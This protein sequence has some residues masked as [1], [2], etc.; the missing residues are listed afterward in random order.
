MFTK[1]PAT[2]TY[3]CSDP[4]P[5]KNPWT[6][7]HPTFL[8]MVLTWI[9]YT[10]W[11]QSIFDISNVRLVQVFHK[12][13]ISHGPSSW[14]GLEIADKPHQQVVNWTG[15]ACPTWALH[16]K[17][18]LSLCQRKKGFSPNSTV[19]LMEQKLINLDLL[20][21]FLFSFFC[22]NDRMGKAAVPLHVLW[23]NEKTARHARTKDP[24]RLVWQRASCLMSRYFP[25]E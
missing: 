20:F 19:C 8:K 13:K 5:Q 12:Q 25:G 3:H 14:G 15:C 18:S 23:I 1:S 10:A 4:V 21:L 24:T 17:S 22:C 9:E 6:Q 2:Q 11:K 16:L 7:N